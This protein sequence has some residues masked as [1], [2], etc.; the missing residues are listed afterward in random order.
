L[1]V[2]GVSALLAGSTGQ[3]VNF[4]LTA[5]LTQVAAAVVVLASI[6]VRWP[7]V[8]LVM[9]TMRGG[10]SRWRRDR[11]QRRQYYAC[12]AVFLAKFVIATA[13]MVPLYLAGAV[14]PLGIAATVVGGVPAAAVCVY[15]CWRI[16]REEPRS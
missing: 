1:I 14:V 11:R 5:I 13:V 15:L 16:L 10:G 4:Y 12:T 3:A 6:L 8:G 2:V 7:L 9:G